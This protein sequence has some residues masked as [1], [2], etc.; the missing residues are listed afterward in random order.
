M[1]IY[2]VNPDG[3]A[4]QGLAVGDLV[5]TGGGTYLITGFNSDGSYQSKLIDSA[6]NTY[7][8]KGS[9]NAVGSSNNSA[10]AGQGVN[11]TAPALT[12][13]FLG[14][15]NEASQGGYQ[16]SKIPKA[17]AMSFEEAMQLAEQVMKPQY[18]ATYASAAE[19]AGQKL[20]QAGLYDTVYGQ[21]LAADAER[22]IS[23]DMN[24]AIMSLALQLSEASDDEAQQLLELAVKERQF[25][26]NYNAEQKSLALKYLSQLISG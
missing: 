12:D 13:K 20:E 25:C 21:S 9:Y 8:F 2:K 11:A 22:D 5:V 7:N 1:G 10:S 15:L 26:A 24:A 3:K 23:R 6:T 17:Q 16:E 14:L 4:P 19:T 18:T